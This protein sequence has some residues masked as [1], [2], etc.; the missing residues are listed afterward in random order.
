MLITWPSPKGLMEMEQ[1]CLSKATQAV[2][3]SISQGR[4]E[5]E[6]SGQAW[7]F[8]GSRDSGVEKEG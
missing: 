6:G 1:S 2:T 3:I 5:N 7:K 4:K 8:L